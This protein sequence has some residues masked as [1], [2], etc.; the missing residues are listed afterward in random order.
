MYVQV[1]NIQSVADDIPID[2]DDNK[3]ID[4]LALYQKYVKFLNEQNNKYDI[5]NKS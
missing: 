5:Y 4:K 1:D 2:Q 3:N